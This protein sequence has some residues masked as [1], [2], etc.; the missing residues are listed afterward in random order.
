MN[1]VYG[2]AQQPTL[3][4]IMPVYNARRYLAEALDSLLKQT[5]APEEIIIIDDG[6]TD[7]TAELIGEYCQRHA[8]IMLLRNP[9]EGVSAARNKGLEV[10]TGQ[11]IYF[12]DADD[13]VGPTL[14]A[15]FI[16]E[17]RVCPQLELYG[18]SAEMFPD[19]PP[20]QRKYTRTHTRSMQ[21]EFSGGSE[22]LRKLIASNSAHRVLWSSIISRELIERT[23]SEF[24]PVQ[25]HEDAPFMLTLY[26]QARRVFFTAN[27]YYYKR[28]AESSLSV[29][30][31]D[32]SWVKNYFI[33][34][35]GT[36]K[37]LLAAGLPL[38]NKLL[39]SYYHPVMIGCLMMVKKHRLRVPKE[40][41]LPL[42]TLARQLTR[43]SLRMSLVWYCHPLYNSLMWC[44]KKLSAFSA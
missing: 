33:V 5:L 16:R 1:T 30:T 25:N 22:M 19:V 21:G 37:A 32:F 9:H 43:N 13:F 4:V 20:E 17:K 44:K 18:F 28:Y 35:E 36:E 6:S 40:Y 39:D 15:D 38:D 29:S 10:A 23:H 2:L 14:F 11:F 34:R 3:S 31:R 27:T 12:M 24:L 8:H 41:Q 7:G 42:N 26:L